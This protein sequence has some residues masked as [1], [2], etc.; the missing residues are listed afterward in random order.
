MSLCSCLEPWPRELCREAWCS[1]T[2]V[3]HEGTVPQAVGL[4]VASS[5]KVAPPAGRVNEPELRSDE[6]IKDYDTG[7][8]IFASGPHLT[9]YHLACGLPS[10][11]V[12]RTVA[13]CFF[14]A[15]F[16][17]LFKREAGICRGGK[18]N[19]SR[20]SCRSLGLRCVSGWASL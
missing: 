12:F 1:L 3:W 20:S 18:H 8:K 7:P 14:F 6:P 15:R 17:K 4:K 19:G 16:S 9:M 5:C 2:W 13:L 10:M 11:P